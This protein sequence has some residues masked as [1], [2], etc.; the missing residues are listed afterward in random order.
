MATGAGVMSKKIH[1][2]NA[3]KTAA[4]EGRWRKAGNYPAKAWIPG[5]PEARAALKDFSMNLRRTA[6]TTVPEDLII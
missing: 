2:S 5:T 6:G 1:K 3:A 4:S